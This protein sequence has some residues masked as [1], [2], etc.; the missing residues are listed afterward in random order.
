[1]RGSVR[2]SVGPKRVFFYRKKVCSDNDA[3]EVDV[4][5]HFETFRDILGH[6]GT[7]RDNLE[8]FTTRLWHLDRFA[9]HFL[10]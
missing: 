1:M 5:G 8:D 4:L 10:P 2:P 9:S 3:S 6:F 7:I